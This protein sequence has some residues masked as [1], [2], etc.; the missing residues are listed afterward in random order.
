MISGRRPEMRSPDIGSG[1]ETEGSKEVVIDVDDV[2]EPM[3]VGTNRARSARLWSLAPEREIKR[4]HDLCT[5]IPFP[6]LD[7]SSD[8]ACDASLTALY[9]YAETLAQSMIDWYLNARRKK[10]ALSITLR[11]LSY[12]FFILGGV[13]PL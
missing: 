5:S 11:T 9:R 3:E 8:I 10:K 2:P 13:V 7:W 12:L 6:D 1:A 4:H